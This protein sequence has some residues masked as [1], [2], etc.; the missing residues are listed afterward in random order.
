[1]RAPRLHNSSLGTRSLSLFDSN[2]LSSLTD[3]QDY[4]C[5]Q[6]SHYFGGQK[7]QCSEV[8]TYSKNVRGIVWGLYIQ[9]LCVQEETVTD[10]VDKSVP[11]LI[12][13]E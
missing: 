13:P 8:L 12:P 11:L 4:I 6:R 2:T 9:V 1:M 3:V 7:M 10:D 5:S